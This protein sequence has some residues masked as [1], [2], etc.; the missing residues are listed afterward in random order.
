MEVGRDLTLGTPFKLQPQLIPF[1][2]DAQHDFPVSITVDAA[3]SLAMLI[4]KMGYLFVFDL[5]TA[6]TLYRARVS[7]DTIFATATTAT[8]A[9]LGLTA[10]KGQLLTIAINEDAI[11]PYI[12]QTLQDNDLAI[13]LA[14][15]L[16]LPGAEA[17]YQLEFEKLM[18]AGD[19][20]GAVTLAVNS[21]GSLRTQDTLN[22]FQQLLTDP[23][24]PQPVFIYFFALLEKGQLTEQESIELSRPVLQ[25]GRA[26][27]LEK[28]LKED[29]LRCSEALG[30]LVM[31]H[32][33]GIALSV[34]LRGKVSPQGVRDGDTGW[35]IVDI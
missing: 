6:K 23:G 3:H 32:D 24:Q 34:Y 25:Q 30:D 17:L 26:A 29:K 10:R 27:L 7:Q 11:I 15:R 5:L 21:G 20:A 16:N 19:T 14:G 8:G 33:V 18:G 31:P 1:P 9:I 4:T 13:K 28:W 12:V 22:R 35:F 2:A